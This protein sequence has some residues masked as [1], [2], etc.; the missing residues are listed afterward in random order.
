MGYREDCIK[1]RWVRC[2]KRIARERARVGLTQEEAAKRAG[3]SRRTWVRLETAEAGGDGMPTIPEKET[4]KRIAAALGVSVEVIDVPPLPPPPALPPGAVA[5][6]GSGGRAWAMNVP[7]WYL[8]QL[9]QRRLEAMEPIDPLDVP[10]RDP[11][12]PLPTADELVTYKVRR[13][14]GTVGFLCS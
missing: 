13:E 12:Q 6:P 10:P 7:S 9:V 3:V 2:G 11:D 5:I 8:P 14:D 1:D 4:L